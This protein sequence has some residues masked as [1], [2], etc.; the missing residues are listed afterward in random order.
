MLKRKI[1]NYLDNWYSKSHKKALIV[2]GA[3]QVGK[4]YII[5]D[6]GL[7]KYGS[8]FIEIN[9]NLN[10]EAKDIF[11]HN[12]TAEYL[13]TQFSILYRAP[14]ANGKKVLLF[15][16]EIQSCPEA[17][18]ALKSF[19]EDQRIDVIAS[20]SLL[21]IHYN[22][23]SSFPVGY[24]E[25][26]TLYPLDFEEYL[27]ALGYDHQTIQL[28]KKHFI[29]KEQIPE[30]L[31]Q[32]FMK[33]FREFI[34]TGGM[35]EVLN[36]FV[37]KKDFNSIFEIQKRILED[38]KSDIAKYATSTEK[39]K[40]REVFN[41]IPFQLGKENKKFQYK[42]VSKGGRS[43]TYE[44]SIQWLVDAGITY[45][46]H[47]L[48]T[49][50]IPLI[51]YKKID[52]FKLYMVDIGLLVAMLGVDAQTQILLNHLGIAKGAVYENIIALFLVQQ[53]YDL[54]Y[55]EKPSGLE[56]DFI[57]SKEEKVYAIEVK[58]SDNVKSKSLN[59]LINNSDVDLGIKL[60][61]KN[62]HIDDKIARI[63]LYLAL[64]I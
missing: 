38:Y 52:I 48:V 9:F 56:V 62:I 36:D 16:D 34:V 3:R 54:Y 24:V 29:N 15:L 42:H 25:R 35:P 12:L 50:E 32:N 55:Y 26:I 59:Y 37:A 27:W 57:I 58:S 22:Q 31:H 41:S 45:K 43:S 28:L 51:S 1:M 40:A 5:R 60:S 14:F 33:L 49:P 4:T 64:F 17:I 19:T 44:G 6:F 10:L 20:G 46:C 2:E 8:N 23:V 63:P 61:S 13:Y 30:A 47:A 39:V 21:G 7:K 11:K 18:T 53:G